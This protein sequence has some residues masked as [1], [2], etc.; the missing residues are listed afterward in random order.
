V[1]HAARYGG[2]VAL[3][4]GLIGPPGTEWHYPGSLASTPVFLGCS[5]IDGHIPASRVHESADVFERMGAAV[6]KRL[7]PGMGHTVNDDEM[8]EARKILDALV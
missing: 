3:S 2:V 8:N 5:D 1:R 6:T 7:Y 4:G